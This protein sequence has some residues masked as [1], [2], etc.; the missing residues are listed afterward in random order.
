[1]KRL[2]EATSAKMSHKLARMDHTEDSILDSW[3]DSSLNQRSEC[4]DYT[5]EGLQHPDVKSSTSSQAP[6]HVL[7][8]LRGL[9][10]PAPKQDD[11]KPLAL[12]QRF[13]MVVEGN[14]LGTHSSLSP[15]AASVAS[16][17]TFY[18]TRSVSTASVTSWTRFMTASSSPAR[19]VTS[20]TTYVTASSG[21][22]SRAGSSK[23]RLQRYSNS[24]PLPYVTLI[25]VFL[26]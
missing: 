20:R 18:T 15:S 16:R 17:T 13:E 10:P 11:L 24:V 25:C 9:I 1:M 2:R 12:R 5:K 26:Q 21:G 8:Y 4:K 19:S 6:E 22:R 3:T 23:L 7:A 14:S